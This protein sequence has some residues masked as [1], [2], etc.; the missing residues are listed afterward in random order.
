[1][2]GIISS[3]AKRRKALC[4]PSQIEMGTFLWAPNRAQAQPSASI[5][6]RPGRSGA[7]LRRSFADKDGRLSA[8]GEANASLRA[9]FHPV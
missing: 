7:S 6:E 1:M 3:F 8:A 9:G 5:C 4:G 2:S